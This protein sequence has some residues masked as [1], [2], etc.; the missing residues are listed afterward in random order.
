LAWSEGANRQRFFIEAHLSLPN[1]SSSHQDF[2]I[3]CEAMQ[4]QIIGVQQRLQV[5]EW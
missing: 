1:V 3:I 5:G 2:E 4:D